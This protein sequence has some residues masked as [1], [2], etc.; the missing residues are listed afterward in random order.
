[1]LYSI[2]LTASHSTP[3][4][5]SPFPTDAYIVISPPL[6]LS[7]SF[8]IYCFVLTCL[9]SY[10]LFMCMWLSSLVRFIH[11][12]LVWSRSGFEMFSVE[13]SGTKYNAYFFSDINHF[14]IGVYVC[15]FLTK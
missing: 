8:L 9:V 2:L 15:V 10:I 14:F 7:C 1:M 13:H 6:I 3:F 5:F 12:P 11:L 4:A